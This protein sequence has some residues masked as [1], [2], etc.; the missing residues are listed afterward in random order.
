MSLS[1]CK[2]KSKVEILT[3]I[4]VHVQCRK[5]LIL[6]L[7]FDLSSLKSSWSPKAIVADFSILQHVLSNKRILRAKF[8]W[9]LCYYVIWHL[10]S[11]IPIGELSMNPIHKQKIRLKMLSCRQNFKVRIWFG[12]ISGKSFCLCKVKFTLVCKIS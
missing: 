2:R 1:I 10:L 6:K 9:L 3:Y 4:S 5:K 12:S 11:I 8:V 7:M